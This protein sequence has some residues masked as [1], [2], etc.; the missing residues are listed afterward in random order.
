M[1]LTLIVL[2]L[3]I[4]KLHCCSEFF[5]LSFPVNEWVLFS[6]NSAIFQLYHAEN[7]LNF[8]EMMMRFSLY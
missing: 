3:L 2:D 4:S 1:T 5:L 6:A 7:K 8:N